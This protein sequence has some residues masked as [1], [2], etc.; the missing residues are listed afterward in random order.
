MRTHKLSNLPGIHER[1]SYMDTSKLSAFGV[2]AVEEFLMD[3]DFGRD[4]AATKT[5]EMREFRVKCRECIDWFVLSVRVVCSVFRRREKKYC[6]S[7][8]SSLSIKNA[9]N[10]SRNSTF[11]QNSPALPASSLTTVMVQCNCCIQ[12]RWMSYISARQLRPPIIFAFK[13]SCKAFKTQFQFNERRRYIFRSSL[14]HSSKLRS[15]ALI[16]Q[17]VRAQRRMAFHL[18]VLENWS[19]DFSYLAVSLLSGI[20]G[21]IDH[22]FTTWHQPKRLAC[23]S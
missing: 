8:F 12:V 16:R 14:V 9:N 2:I 18:L 1:E 10:S 15:S 19:F 4:L 23:A 21:A 7:V 20:S 13:F 3:C 11:Q 5:G 6:Y 22:L 17:P